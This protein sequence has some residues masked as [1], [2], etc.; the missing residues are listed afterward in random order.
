[1]DEVEETTGGESEI[2]LKDGFRKRKVGEGKA[3]L[4]THPQNIT[5][6]RIASILN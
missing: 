2:T 6:A 3:V 5:T 1:M 4:R